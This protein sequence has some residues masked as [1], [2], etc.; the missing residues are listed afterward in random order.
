MKILTT[1]DG[2]LESSQVLATV[3][4]LA[5]GLGATVVLLTVCDPAHELLRMHP[6]PSGPALISG[7]AALVSSTQIEVAELNQPTPA[8]WA[9]SRDQSI[10]RVEAEARDYLGEAGRPLREAGVAVESRVLT[11]DNAAKAIIDVAR[12][13]KADIVAMA[14]HGRSGL[15]NIVHGSVASAVVRSGV[16][17]VLLVRSSATRP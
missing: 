4:N 11:A 12:Q 14:T 10:S 9:E 13:E 5:K 2:S 6:E 8:P 3:S 1:L 7:P 16:A 15:R 17:P